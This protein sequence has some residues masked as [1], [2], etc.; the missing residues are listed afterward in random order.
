MIERGHCKQR[1]L[2]RH[3]FLN[4]LN[5]LLGTTLCVSQDQLFLLAKT[6]ELLA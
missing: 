4:H 2:G 6:Q 5:K 1:K 3:Y